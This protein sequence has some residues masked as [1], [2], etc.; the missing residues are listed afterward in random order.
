MTDALGS[1]GH[2]RGITNLHVVKAGLLPMLNFHLG[3]VGTSEVTFECPPGRKLLKHRLLHASDSGA[4]LL[5][6]LSN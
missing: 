2:S 4:A 1:V 5:N 3:G 6:H